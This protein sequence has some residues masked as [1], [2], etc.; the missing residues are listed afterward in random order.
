MARIGLKEAFTGAEQ[1]DNAFLSSD[2]KDEWAGRSVNFTISELERDDESK[3]G[4]RWILYV[5][6][7]EGEPR[8][9]SLACNSRRDAQFGA[10]LRNLP[11]DGI[12]P[13]NLCRRILGDGK[14]A[15]D[16]LDAIDEQ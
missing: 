8:R 10:M 2:E 1:P 15:W 14:T 9:I 5:T 7:G 4:A 13:L 3:Y 12:G 6:T 11:A 16:L